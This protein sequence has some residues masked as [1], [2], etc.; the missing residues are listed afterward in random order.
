MEP[1]V[2]DAPARARGAAERATEFRADVAGF[3]AHLERVFND[4]VERSD[5]QIDDLYLAWCCT[6]GCQ[7]A[8]ETLWMRHVPAIRRAASSVLG[9][10]TIADDVVQ[11]VL[12]RLLVGSA[13][14][15]ATLIDYRGTSRLGR[16]LRSITIRQALT[17]R[18]DDRREVDGDP[19]F[20]RLAAEGNDPELALVKG[21]SGRAVET[22]VRQALAKLATSERLVLQQHL[23]D[24]LSIDEVAGL[25]RVHRATAARRIATA[26]EALMRA[27][28]RELRTALAVDDDELD[29]MIE[30]ARSRLHISLR[31]F[32][33][34]SGASEP[35]EAASEPF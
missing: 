4:G 3:T 19:V 32:A 28:R 21:T 24:G 5:E 20:A 35:D 30:V 2:N 13:E 18:R 7:R 9:N 34:G 22:A 29:S 6:N 12:H 8:L 11:N 16:W 17:V 15:R 14:R 26:R 23:V 25:Y 1:T 10:P 33:D 27:I 31:W